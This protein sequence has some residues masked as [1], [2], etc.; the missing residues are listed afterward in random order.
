MDVTQGCDLGP[1]QYKT[2]KGTTD[3]L[4]QK[5]CS[6][7]GPY[8]IFTGERDAAPVVGHLAT[9]V[10]IRFSSFESMLLKPQKTIK[11]SKTN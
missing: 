11:F 8:D 7:R 1:G 10:R 9:M 6:I 4:L 5:Q 3:D 2:P